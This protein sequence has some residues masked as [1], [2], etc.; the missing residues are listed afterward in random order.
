MY[1]IILGAGSVG[2][3]IAKHLSS[4]GKEVLLIERDPL[5]I[6]NVT[7]KL[8]CQVL[9][10]SIPTIDLLQRA[11]IE[12][13]EFFIATTDLDEVNMISCGIVGAEFPNVTK[14]ARV[15]NLEYSQEQLHAKQFLNIDYV[16]NPDIEAAEAI[17]R[18]IEYGAISE[19]FEFVEPDIQIRDFLV[20]KDSFICDKKVGDL[21]TLSERRFLIAAVMRKGEAF[22]PG[23]QFV[24]EE[25]DYLYIA[26]HRNDF[27]KLVQSFGAQQQRIR[28]IVIVGAGRIGQHILQRLI[29]RGDRRKTIFRRRKAE[30][31]EIWVI[32]KDIERCKQV[33]ADFPEVTVLHGDLSEEDIFVEENLTNADLLISVTDNQEINI[34]AAQY[35]KVLGVPRSIAL[36][37][38]NS[39]ANIATK[40]GID[41]SVN[42][43]NTVVNSILRFLRSKYLKSFQTILEG[44]I[45]FWELEIQPDSSVV[46]KPISEINLGGGVALVVAISREGG[47]QLIIPT[48]K[49]VMQERDHI[50][51]VALKDSVDKLE[52]LLHGKKL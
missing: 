16:V 42:K 41:V 37:I 33:A 31:L 34:V 38:K 23:G 17:L 7:N 29:P 46:N 36:V 35:A 15:R 26:S 50:V 28:R 11:G 44:E 25:N 14:V 22:I 12:K 48:G 32:E 6:N 18:S 45:E 9:E 3:Q 52:P 19:V 30:N 13:A 27:P 51:L 43:K 5:V 49:E 24:V 10:G 20:H 21:A 40:L 8:N 1:C 47:K 2:M 39:Y 4:E